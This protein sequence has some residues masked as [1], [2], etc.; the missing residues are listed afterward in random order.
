MPAGQNFLR[1]NG[2]SLFDEYIHSEF[3]Y[4]SFEEFYLQS[5]SIGQNL[6]G[7]NTVFERKPRE[8]KLIRRSFGAAAAQN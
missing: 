5:Y 4:F 2:K 1:C 8:V 6:P 7:D 3:Q